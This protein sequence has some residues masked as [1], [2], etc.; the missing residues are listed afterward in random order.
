MDNYGLI[1][2]PPFNY[3][4]E[5][6]AASFSP[7]AGA[8]PHVLSLHAWTSISG[9]ILVILRIET[10]EL[11]RGCGIGCETCE[12]SGDDLNQLA[13]ILLPCAAGYPASIWSASHF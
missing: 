11:E 9:S 13:E 12:A 2:S 8:T 7:P 10:F 5:R 4:S 6:C 1:L 3:C